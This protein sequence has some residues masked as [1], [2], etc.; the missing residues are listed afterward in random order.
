ME[1]DI[2]SQKPSAEIPPKLLYANLKLP[3]LAKFTLQ[4]ALKYEFPVGLAPDASSNLHLN[5][6]AESDPFSPEVPEVPEVP[7]VPTPEVPDVPSPPAAPSKLVT[8]DE[9]APL[10]FIS[11]TLTVKLPDMPLYSTTS[12]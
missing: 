3:M 6:V 7:S 9:K 4:H 1:F 10:P 11:V 8:H 2:V 12:P 5:V